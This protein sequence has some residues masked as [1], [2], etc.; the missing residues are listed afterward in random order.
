MG[1]VGVKDLVRITFVP[2]S[3]WSA[4]VRLEN[5]E[6]PLIGSSGTATVDLNGLADIMWPG[7]ANNVEITELTL[8]GNQRLDKMRADKIQWNSTDSAN[9]ER[10]LTELSFDTGNAQ[11][12]P[13]RIRVFNLAYTG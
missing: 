9:L 2:K 6:D 7:S 5:L 13:Q 4:D 11:L 8:T 1:A 3:G 10:K 12:E